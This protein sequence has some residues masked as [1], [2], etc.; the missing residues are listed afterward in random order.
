MNIVDV[1]NIHILQ[2]SNQI[3]SG[4]MSSLVFKFELQ[5]AIHQQ[6]GIA[7]QEVSLNSV[8]SAVDDQYPDL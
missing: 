8:G 2:R 6:R 1:N 7:D 4:N 5:E 3:I